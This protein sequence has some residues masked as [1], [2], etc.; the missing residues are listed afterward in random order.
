MKNL[1]NIAFVLVLTLLAFTGTFAE[2]YLPPDAGESVYS[3][4]QPVFSPV[5]AV[6]TSIISVST[7]R[8]IT[9]GSTSNAIGET[10]EL[11]SR[12]VVNRHSK[13]TE[14]KSLAP[15]NFSRNKFTPN[16]N[17]AINTPQRAADANDGWQLIQRE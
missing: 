12:D 1:R 10:P 8:D 3:I 2:T 5:A 11:T 9:V 7:V 16:I 6:S 15:P 4:D 14:A 13:L 17:S